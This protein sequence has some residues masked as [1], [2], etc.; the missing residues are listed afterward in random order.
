M[1]AAVGDDAVTPRDRRSITIVRV[2][3]RRTLWGR[4]WI[5]RSRGPSSGVVHQSIVTVWWTGERLHSW[6]TFRSDARRFDSYNEAI[7]EWERLRRIMA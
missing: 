2:R 5:I 1:V 7:Q 3:R 4:Q 6:S